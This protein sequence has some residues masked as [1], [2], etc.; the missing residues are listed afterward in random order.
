MLIAR[1]SVI[2]QMQALQHNRARALNLLLLSVA[3][4]L[5]FCFLGARGLW[6][7]EGRWA[8]VTREMFLTQDFFYPTIG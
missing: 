8:E 2:L 5:L 4:V 3:F 7:A 1:N 6:A